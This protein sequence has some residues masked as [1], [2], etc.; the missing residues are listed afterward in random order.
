MW[1][2]SV[3]IILTSILFGVI[4]FYLTLIAK[5]YRQK[6]Q[7]GPPYRFLQISLSVL[8]V[9]LILNLKTFAF[10]PH[11]VPQGLVCLGG[12]VFAYCGYALYKTMMSIS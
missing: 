10:I 3:G 6:F 12:A 5:F 1:M 11:I 2:Q 9:G 7:K 4:G 8:I